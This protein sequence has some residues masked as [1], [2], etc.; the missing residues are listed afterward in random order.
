MIKNKTEILQA[1]KEIP[2]E[3]TIGQSYVHEH[4]LK[5]ESAAKLY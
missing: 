3:V 1:S 2:V 4:V 5:P